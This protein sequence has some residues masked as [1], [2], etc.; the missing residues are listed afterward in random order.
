MAP[1]PTRLRL[2]PLAAC[3]AGLLVCGAG[4]LLKLDAAVLATPG[5]DLLACGAILAGLVLARH[6]LVALRQ[7]AGR[8]APHRLRRYGPPSGGAQ[9]LPEL[10]PPG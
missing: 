1:D 3:A 4:A 2:C 5:R 8:A 7:D 9:R 10:A 6:V